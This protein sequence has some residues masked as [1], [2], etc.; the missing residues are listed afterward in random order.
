MR[1]EFLVVVV[2]A[3]PRD[4]LPFSRLRRDFQRLGSRVVG[5][6]PMDPG[7]AARAVSRLGLEVT[8]ACDPGGRIASAFGAA[9]RIGPFLRVKTT[10]FIIR[11]GVVEEVVSGFSPGVQALRALE[12]IKEARGA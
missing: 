1:A 6:L 3:S 2:A 10:T 8:V 4:L 7:R 9:R 12:Y 5:V 11:R